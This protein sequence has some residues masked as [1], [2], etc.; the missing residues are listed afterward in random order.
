MSKFFRFSVAA[1]FLLIAAAPL[2]AQNADGIEVL[3][4]GAVEAPLSEKAKQ[5]A[6]MKYPLPFVMQSV[7]T[8]AANGFRIAL[9]QD[10]DYQQKRKLVP[11]LD[12]VIEKAMLNVVNRVVKQRYSEYIDNIAIML[13]RNYTADELGSMIDFYATPLGQRYVQAVNSAPDIAMLRKMLTAAQGE[14]PDEKL[15]LLS[16]SQFDKA[17]GRLSADDQ[18][19]LNRWFSSALGIKMASL[20][21]EETRIS[22][23]WDIAIDDQMLREGMDEMMAAA[24]NYASK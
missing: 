11:G 18:L 9:S 19:A 2:Y 24:A 10:P 22:S 23:N 12:T 4:A 6:A 8:N 3:D 21:T 16:K 1:P 7:R 13:D 20:M 14:N 5:L 15:S 17:L